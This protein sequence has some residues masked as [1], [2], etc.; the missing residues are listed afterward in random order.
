[1]YNYRSEYIFSKLHSGWI[2][3][4]FLLIRNLKINIKIQ[5]RENNGLKWSNRA[6]EIKTK[7]FRQHVRTRAIA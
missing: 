3:I 4:G 2:T 5:K 6:V 7:L 1:M